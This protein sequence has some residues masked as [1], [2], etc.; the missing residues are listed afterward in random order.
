M[1][2]AHFAH[3][4]REALREDGEFVLYRSQ[5]GGLGSKATL[6]A[7]SSREKL[8]AQLERRT[9]ELKTSNKEL[10]AFAYSTSHDLGA[11][12]RHVTA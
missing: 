6:S 4:A 11:P 3:G 12:L 9:L 5:Y 2:A 8:N 10:E 1:A 7:C